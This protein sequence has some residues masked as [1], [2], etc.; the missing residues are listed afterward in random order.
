MR[1][2]REATLLINSFIFTG[3]QQFAICHTKTSGHTIFLGSVLTN[4]SNFQFICVISSPNPQWRHKNR[5]KCN[6]STTGFLFVSALSITYQCQHCYHQHWHQPPSFFIVCL[7][8][9]MMHALKKF[10]TTSLKIH[11]SV[12]QPLAINNSL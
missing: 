9:I 6:A 1:G 4:K 11:R 5:T 10:L 12:S 7:K 2:H 8:K 3:I